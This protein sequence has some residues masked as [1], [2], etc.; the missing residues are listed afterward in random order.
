MATEEADLRD[1]EVWPGVARMWY[2]K[3]TDKSRNVGRIQHH[4]AVLARPNIVQ[5]LF[6]Y[7]K[8]LGSVIPSQNA[9]VDHA[10]F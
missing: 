7:S 6:H 9:G 4:L 3:A 2:N 8:A 10:S 5:Q 1:R